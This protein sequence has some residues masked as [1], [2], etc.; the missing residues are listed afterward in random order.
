[1]GIPAWIGIGLVFA[2]FFSIHYMMSKS[3]DLQRQQSDSMQSISEQIARLAADLERVSGEIESLQ[4]S[5]AD[6]DRAL[7]R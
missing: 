2:Y 6:I 5:I 1:M 4:R 3:V 7:D